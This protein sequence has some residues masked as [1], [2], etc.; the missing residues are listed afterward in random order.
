MSTTET[1]IADT[2]LRPALNLALDQIERL[3]TVVTPDQAP[4]PTPCSEFDVSTL[5]DHLQG[6][7]RRLAVILSGQHFSTAPAI[8]ASTSWLP[9]W[10]EGRTALAPLLADDATLAREATVPWGTT[11]GAGA[12][13][14]YLGEL[15]THAWDLA[16]A[17]GHLDELDPTLA[18]LALPTYQTILPATPR[19]LPQIPFGAVVEVGLDA[20][21]YEQLVAW[22]GRDP[23]WS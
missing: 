5:V 12:I 14:S 16:A 19:A 2:D 8:V 13:A 18:E 17:T 1:R 21:P 11:T 4:L 9:D 6:V 3:L 10:T 22:T 7:V 23:R 15:T 20:G